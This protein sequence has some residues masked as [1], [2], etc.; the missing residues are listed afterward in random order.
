MRGRGAPA[1]GGGFTRGGRGGFRGGARGGRGSG[2][3][4]TGPPA[5][6]IGKAFDDARCRNI[7]EVGEVMHTCQEELVCKCTLEQQVP[8][9]NGRIFLENK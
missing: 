5:S 4:A 1:R 7:V 8:Y 2:F 3:V 6:V 9:F